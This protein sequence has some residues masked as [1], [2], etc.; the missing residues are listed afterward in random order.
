MVSDKFWGGTKYFFSRVKIIW[1]LAQIWAKYLRQKIDH[2]VW[3][4]FNFKGG[5]ELCMPLVMRSVWRFNEVKLSKKCFFIFSL[6][7]TNFKFP[8]FHDQK[9]FFF[10]KITWFPP[11]FDRFMGEG[12]KKNFPL[13]KIKKSKIKK[14]QYLVFVH[15]WNK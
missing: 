13:L 15:Y 1:N 9:K 7:K 14:K 3:D 5:G 11:L 12:G 6:G 4:Y 10:P 2:K 8:I